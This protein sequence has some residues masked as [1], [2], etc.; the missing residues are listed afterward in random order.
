METNAQK[1]LKITRKDAIIAV[2]KAIFE[3][4]EEAVMNLYSDVSNNLLE[5]ML[6]RY[7]VYD[8]DTVVKVKEHL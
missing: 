8:K 1:P 2:I 3:K 6:Y 5:E 4:D 7:G